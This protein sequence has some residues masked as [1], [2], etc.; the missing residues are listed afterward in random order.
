MAVPAAP[1]GRITRD[2]YWQLVEEGVIGPDDRVELLEGVIVSMSPQN[3]PH[4][5]VMTAL[6]RLLAS[7]VGPGFL[8]RVQLPLDVSAFS[9]PEPDFAVVPGPAE[10][11]LAAHPTS[12]LLIVEVADST[13]T[14]DRLTKGPLYAAAGFPEYWIVNLRDHCVET[15]R[16]PVAAE[17][18]YAET[19]IARAGDRLEPLR[20]PGVSLAVADFLPPARS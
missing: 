17:R 16:A 10:D 13:L 1:T 7:S 11:Y 9:T 8:V 18:R 20:L 4:A 6:N 5:F 12:A 2:R 15:Y 14:Q 3:P 19:R